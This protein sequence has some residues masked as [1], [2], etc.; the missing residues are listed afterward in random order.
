[1][2]LRIVEPSFSGP[3]SLPLNLQQYNNENLISYLQVVLEM[4][5]G[6]TEEH[7]IPGKIL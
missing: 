2:F 5:L 3:S 4:W 1:M 7:F 6:I